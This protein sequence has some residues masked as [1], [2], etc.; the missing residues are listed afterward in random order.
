[1]NNLNYPLTNDITPII[2]DYRANILLKKSGIVTPT[3]QGEKKLGYTIISKLGGKIK[4]ILG[5]IY[6]FSL[7]FFT[8]KLFT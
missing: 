5:F 8:M 4:L 7:L 2:R 1:M 6:L 3:I